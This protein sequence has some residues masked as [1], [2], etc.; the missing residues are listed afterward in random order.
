M[1]G[2]GWP[3]GGGRTEGRTDGRMEGRT[4]GRTDGR[5]SGNS[6]LC[7]TGHRPFEAAAQKGRKELMIMQL[8]KENSHCSFQ[9][10]PQRRQCGEGTERKEADTTRH[11]RG[12][13]INTVCTTSNTNLQITILVGISSRIQIHSDVSAPSGYLWHSVKMTIEIQLQW[14]TY[15]SDCRSSLLMAFEQTPLTD[16]PKM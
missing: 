14:Q 7:P 3:T 1:K 8:P 16:P 4:D 11:P 5:T 15:L 10:H 13:R 12:K 2:P 9:D 6:P